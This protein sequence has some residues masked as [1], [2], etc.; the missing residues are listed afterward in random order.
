MVK[1][2]YLK[3]I[4]IS[5][6]ST[7]MQTHLG[8]SSHRNCSLKVGVLKNFVMITG[9]HLCGSLFFINLQTWRPTTL[10]IPVLSYEYCETFKATILKITLRTAASDYT[11]KQHLFSYARKISFVKISLYFLLAFRGFGEVL[12]SLS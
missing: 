11:Y 1:H 4:K 7:E 9:N 10:L 2:F 5:L 12:E 3:M 6:W 8:R